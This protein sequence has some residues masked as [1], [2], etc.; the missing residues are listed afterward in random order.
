M[1][2]ALSL[3]QATEFTCELKDIM[4]KGTSTYLVSWHFGVPQV[5]W[6]Q[7]LEPLAVCLA[8][9][10]VNITEELCGSLTACGI[11]GLPKD[12]WLSYLT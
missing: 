10:I 3:G 6:A 5:F 4:Y 2:V 11:H 7:N 12:I 1:A 8:V 9:R